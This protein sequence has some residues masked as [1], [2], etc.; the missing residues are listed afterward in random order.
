SDTRES[1]D[2]LLADVC[3]NAEHGAALAGITRALV[4]VMV[5]QWSEGIAPAT[6]SVAELRAS[7]WW[8]AVNGLEGKL[9]SPRTR[10]LGAV[11]DVV[12]E[13]LELVRPVLREYDEYGHVAAVIRDMLQHGNGSRSQR[14]AYALKQDPHDVVADALRRTHDPNHSQG[15]P[16]AILSETW[17]LNDTEQLPIAASW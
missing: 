1:V 17:V 5:R 9:M 12:L 13:L 3:L 4:E 15:V 8:A 16:G 2:V 11:G 10:R 7:S 6:T 14:N